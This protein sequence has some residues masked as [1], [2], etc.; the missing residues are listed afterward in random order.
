MISRYAFARIRQRL[1]THIPAPWP[2]CP[3]QCFRALADGKRVLGNSNIE[4]A[5]CLGLWNYSFIYELRV[6]AKGA[7]RGLCALVES[8]GYEGHE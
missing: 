7:V 6:M 4:R 1:G 5:K 3:P 2:L 8:G